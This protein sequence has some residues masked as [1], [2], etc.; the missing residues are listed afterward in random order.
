MLVPIRCFHGP[1]QEEEV[2]AAIRL[3]QSTSRTAH[4]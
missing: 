4:Q 1:S 3:G 2:Q